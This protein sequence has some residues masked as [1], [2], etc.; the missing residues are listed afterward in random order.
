MRCGGVGL[1]IEMPASLGK[2][3]TQQLY[4]MAIGAGV[5]ECE[6]KNVSH[7]GPEVA[8]VPL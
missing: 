4:A 6:G 1:A 3:V 5:L 2:G 8:S 7:D